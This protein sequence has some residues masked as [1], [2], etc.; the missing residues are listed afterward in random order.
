MTISTR[1]VDHFHDG[2]ELL[3]EFAYDDNASG[4]RPGIMVCHNWAGRGPND[5]RN[6]HRLAAL[7]YT[8]FAVDL[9]G[10]GVLGT[11]PEENARLMQPFI[12]DR[13]LLQSRLAAAHAAMCEQPEVDPNRT[14]VIGFC[15]GGLCAL[16][17]A[18]AALPVKGAVSFHGLF[19]PAGNL[20]SPDISAKVLILHGWDDPMATPEDVLSVSSEMSAAGADWQLHAYGGTAHAFTTPGAN[21]PDMG[22][23]YNEAADRRSWQAMVNFLAEVLG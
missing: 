7:G 14:A 15:F 13:A 3:A 10:K 18:R 8:G 19:M 4:P 1:F 20:S 11:G 22:T 5:G 23:V 16:D 2:T 9:Y 21:N 12:D 17:M 6:A